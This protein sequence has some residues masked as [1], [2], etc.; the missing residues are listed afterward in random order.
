MEMGSLRKLEIESLILRCLRR[1]TETGES[2]GAK[3]RGQGRSEYSDRE[4]FIYSIS[5]AFTVH[6][7]KIRVIPCREIV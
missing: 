7:Y 4:V 3:P 5:V 6:T 2:K 1:G